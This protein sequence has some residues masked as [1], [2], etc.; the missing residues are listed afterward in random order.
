M[1][2]LSDLP[3]AQPTDDEAK[4]KERQARRFKEKLNEDQKI[5]R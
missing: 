4:A 2:S 1:A 5:R 3:A